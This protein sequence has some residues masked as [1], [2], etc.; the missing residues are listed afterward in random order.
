MSDDIKSRL[1][2]WK[3]LIQDPNSCPDACLGNFSVAISVC[4]KYVLAIEAAH[5]ALNKIKKLG[6]D[7]IDHDAC[8]SCCALKHLKTILVMDNQNA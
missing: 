3:K 5:E 7:S 6:C 4:E 2:E 1:A 8:S